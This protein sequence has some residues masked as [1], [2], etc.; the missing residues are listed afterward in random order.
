[1]NIDEKSVNLQRRGNSSG[2][3]EELL[4]LERVLMQMAK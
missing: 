4:K 1:M 3:D 2:S